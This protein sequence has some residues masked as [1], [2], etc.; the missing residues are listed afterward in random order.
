MRFIEKQVLAYL[1]CSGYSFLKFECGVEMKIVKLTERDRARALKWL[2]KEPELNLF[3][4]GDI[5]NFGFDAD[6]QDVWAFQDDRG[7]IQGIVLRYY[8]HWIISF[9]RSKDAIE[10]LPLLSS[11]K[12]PLNISG[13]LSAIELLANALG[14]GEVKRQFFASRPAES[15][16]FDG[17]CEL[18]SEETAR[19]AFEFLDQIEEFGNARSFESFN[20]G[21]VS[22]TSRVVILR[23]DGRIIST[24]S[25]TAENS[26]NAMIIGVATLAGFRKL[27]YATRVM[28]HLLQLLSLEHKASCLFYSN[29]EAGRI[30]KGLGYKDIGKW[31][32]LNDIT[33]N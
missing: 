8:L 4:I 2:K 9:S 30:Y 32:I 28:N 29:P 18:V 26:V 3:I 6:F 24:A 1:V 17:E 33:F 19:E 12:Q 5:E 21:I 20:R 16:Q 27:G 31:G 13:E 10:S 11:A 22:G 14:S 7:K 25:S 23:K 15:A